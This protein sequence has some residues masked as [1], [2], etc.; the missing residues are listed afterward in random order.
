M[1]VDDAGQRRASVV[2]SVVTEISADLSPPKDRVKAKK[3]KGDVGAEA[4]K[5]VKKA[6]T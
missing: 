6:K 5:K 3:R 4:T 2:E 1:E